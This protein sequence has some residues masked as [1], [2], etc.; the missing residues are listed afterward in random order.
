MFAAEIWFL[1]AELTVGMLDVVPMGAPELMMS[2]TGEEQLAEKADLLR[3][4]D[5]RFGTDF[6]HKREIR[7]GIAEPEIEA[8]EWRLSRWGGT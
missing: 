6:G 8:G 1:C 3:E 2:F 7:K 5:E 4:R